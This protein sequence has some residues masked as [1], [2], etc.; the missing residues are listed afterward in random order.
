MKVNRIHN[1]FV[2]KHID[3]G[4]VMWKIKHIF[5]GE[6]GCEALQ[7]GESPKVSVTLVNDDGEETF[8]L[9]EDTWLVENHL[10]VGAIWPDRKERE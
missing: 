3:G 7:P 4:N 2:D 5:D 10:D 9:V 6:Y 1:H 8:V